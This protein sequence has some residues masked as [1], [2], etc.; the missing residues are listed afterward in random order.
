MDEKAMVAH[1]NRVLDTIEGGDLNSL[2]SVYAPHIRVWHNTDE[3]DQ[4]IDENLE[5]LRGVVENLSERRYTD[6]RIKV[7]DGGFVEQHVLKGRLSNGQAFRLPA[8]IICTV[9]GD[10]IT[11]IDEYLDMA[12]IQKHS[13]SES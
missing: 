12:T 3:I 7:F 6:R 5:Q 4:S 8:C 2:R 9:E 11:R 13:S 1:C 10:R